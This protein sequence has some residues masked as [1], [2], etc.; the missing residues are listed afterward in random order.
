MCLCVA[1][2]RRHGEVSH[3]CHPLHHCPHLVSYLH[4]FSNKVSL[5]ISSA[6]VFALTVHFKYSFGDTVKAKND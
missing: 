5:F 3:L 6:S 4:D 2:A 1:E